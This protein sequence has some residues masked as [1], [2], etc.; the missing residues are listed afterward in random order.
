VN[1]EDEQVEEEEEEENTKE[2]VEYQFVNLISLK[3]GSAFP[4][5]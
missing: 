3:Y 5:H 1:E 2:I 4:S